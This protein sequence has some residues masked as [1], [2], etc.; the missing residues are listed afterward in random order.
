MYMCECHGYSMQL[1]MQIIGK[2]W[3][4]CTESSTMYIYYVNR[5]GPVQEFIGQSIGIRR[6]HCRSTCT[7]YRKHICN[8]IGYGIK[9]LLAEYR[10][11]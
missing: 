7:K 3:V 11:M 2:C 8:Y 5:L 6:I 10:N 9:I 4:F 1:V